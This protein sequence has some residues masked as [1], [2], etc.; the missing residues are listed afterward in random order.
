MVGFL[1]LQ[2]GE[3]V[4]AVVCAY[5]LNAFL[6]SLGRVLECAPPGNSVVL[7]GDFNTNVGMTV[8]PGG[9]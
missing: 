5:V 2:V 4:L 9:A 7:L 1:R 3:W 8:R 6:E